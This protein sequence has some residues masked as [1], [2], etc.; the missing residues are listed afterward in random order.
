MTEYLSHIQNTGWEV[1]VAF[2]VANLIAQ[3]IKIMTVAIK[4]RTFKWTILFATGGMPSSHSSTVVAMA[5]SVGLI[6][7]FAS[8]NYAIAVCFAT[9]VM[10]DAAGLRRNASKQAMV[11]NRM[12]KQLLSPDSETGKV[13]LKEFL[14][15]TPTEVLV[16]AILGVAVS[17]AL[18]YWSDCM[19]YLQSSNS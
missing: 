17:F 11:L 7:G 12:I 15:H 8:T 19:L 5:T 13:K 4:K 9:V 3:F 16:G 14:G 10:F 6:D 2:I 18:H 1:I